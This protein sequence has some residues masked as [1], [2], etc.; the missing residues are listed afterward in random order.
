MGG[1]SAAVIMS[2]VVIP[3]ALSGQLQKVRGGAGCE[4]I[5]AKDVIHAQLEFAGIAH[6]HLLMATITTEK[7]PLIPKPSL[8]PPHEY[9][10]ERRAEDSGTEFKSVIG[11]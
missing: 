4:A 7:P 11:V 2:P 8:S 10:W 3:L 1:R 6:C 5:S 9:C